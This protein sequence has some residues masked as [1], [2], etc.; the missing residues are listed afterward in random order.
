MQKERPKARLI[1]CARGQLG[2]FTLQQAKACGISTSTLYRK[3]ASDWSVVHPRVFCFGTVPSSF[4]QRLLAAV[5]W[6]GPE[7]FASHR[8]AA[9]LWGLAGC[10]GAEVEISVSRVLRSPDGKA[11]VHCGVKRGC[12]PTTTPAIPVTSVARTLFELGAVAPRSVVEQAT[13]DALRRRLTAVPLLE[14]ELQVESRQGKRG[15]KHLRAVLDALS[16]AV[17]KAESV[18]ELRL[19][20]V[21]E[22]AGLRPAAQHQVTAGGRRYRLDFAFPRERVALEADGKQSH[23]L[24]SD[25]ERDL[26]RRNA[27]TAEGWC[28]LHFSWDRVRRE[29]GRIV[30]EVVKT[31][32]ARGQA[33]R[34]KG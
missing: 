3:A 7:A 9:R 24:A 15:A 31:M 20:S 26:R 33:Q 2:L 29:P 22:R 1:A 18:L 4:E 13:R 16:P 14:M 12:G 21:L 10:E 34:Q 23:F 17:P 19:L 32:G 5:L 30:D 27:L 28:V 6:A 8:A 25:W 11:I